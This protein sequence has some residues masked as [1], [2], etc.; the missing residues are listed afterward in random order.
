MKIK[1]FILI[2]LF[3]PFFLYS[4]PIE[5]ENL[6]ELGMKAFKIK[7][8]KYSPTSSDN[9]F[10]DFHLLSENGEVYAAIL[11]F[12]KGYLILAADDAVVPVLAYDFVN[13][14]DINDVAPASLQ[15]LEQ[16][17]NEILAVRK[18]NI[19]PDKKALDGWNK[20]LGFTTINTENANSVGPLLKSS[21]NQNKYYNYY[22]PVDENSPVGYDYKTPNGCVAVAMSQIMYYYRYPKKGEGYYTNYSSYGS[23]FVNFAQQTYNYDAMNDVLSFYNNEVS[24]LIFH[25]GVSVDMNYGTNGSGAYSQEVP[26]AMESYFGYNFG[27]QYISKD[28]YD[29]DGWNNVLKSDLNQLRP[30][31]YSGYSEEGGHA[32]V[33]DGYNDEDYFHFNFG[34]GGSGDGFFV[35]SST[36]ENQEV[37]G[38]YS[39]Y[40]SAIIRL[41][42]DES[43]YPEYCDD[44]TITALYGTLEDGSGNMDYSNNQYCT[45]LITAPQQYAVNVILRSVDTEENH[46]FIRF[47]NGHPSKDS[48]LLEVSGGMPS[49]NNYQFDTDSLYITFE[50]DEDQVASGWSLYYFSYRDISG[51]GNH[52][53]YTHSGN[54]SSGVEG[55]NYRDNSNCVWNIRIND[56]QYIKFTFNKLDI[57]PEDH[58][59]F[60]DIT[61]NPPQLL[62][63]ITGNIIPEP[64]TIPLRKVRVVFVSDNYLNAEG[65]DID[66]STD[67]TYGITNLGDLSDV[68]SNIYPNPASNNINVDFKEEF[69]YDNLNGIKVSV[70]DAV[71]KCVISDVLVKDTKVTVPTNNLSEGLFLLKIDVEGRTFYRKFVIRH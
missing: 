27:A 53:Y 44:R 31:Y 26:N 68:V 52:T 47:W 24:K 57:S 23:F 17:K 51:C 49:N 9:R 64:L 61:Y 5:K 43:K 34:W 4:N 13:N 25:C 30:V 15:L 67:Q 22:S 41:R 35:T 65:F 28:H 32:F 12:D 46:D 70:L 33:C 59:D 50:T 2:L 20:I 60:Y 18:Y 58:L 1:I 37:T 71:G 8:E 14:F 63:S 56:A 54:I 38:G 62:Q 10:K 3:V 21:W 11:N 45:Y 7:A 6:K 66:W 19:S 39:G 42:P 55:I 16:Y 69:L 29:N 40:Q 48:L 36:S